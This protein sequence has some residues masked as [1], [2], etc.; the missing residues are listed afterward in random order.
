MCIRKLGF[1]FR[2][3]RLA[4]RSRR[5]QLK[6]RAAAQTHCEV[7]VKLVYNRLQADCLIMDAVQILLLFFR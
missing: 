6:R 7:V 4:K 3:D 5:H 2:P 1:V